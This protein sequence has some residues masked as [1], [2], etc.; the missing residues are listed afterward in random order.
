M[1]VVLITLYLEIPKC[2]CALFKDVLATKLS[3]SLHSNELIVA[4]S[5]SVRFKSSFG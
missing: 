1:L 3:A 5:L 2:I 4:S